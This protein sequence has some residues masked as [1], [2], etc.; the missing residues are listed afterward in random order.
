MNPEHLSLF[1]RA[2][3]GAPAIVI[4]CIAVIVSLAGLIRYL[5]GQLERRDVQF[6]AMQARTLTV[7][8]NNTEAFREL[9]DTIRNR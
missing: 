2:A 8:A 5:M 1:E 9:R 7:I 4:L 6:I 3:Q